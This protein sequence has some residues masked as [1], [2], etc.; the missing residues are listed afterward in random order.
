[1]RIRHTR[2]LRDWSSD[3]CSSDLQPSSF[4][5]T[6]FNP[7]R[8]KMVRRAEDWPWSSLGGAA[9]SNG[10]KLKLEGWPVERPRNWLEI[11]NER[12]ERSEE[13]RVG[14]ERRERVGG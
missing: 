5:F 4:S 7:L 1:S 14:E 12:M 8:A 6:P 2:S 11:V 10:V 13:R 9:G 3:V